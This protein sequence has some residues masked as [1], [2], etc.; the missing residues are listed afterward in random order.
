MPICEEPIMA[1]DVRLST[2]ALAMLSAQISP[3]DSTPEAHYLRLQ[4]GLLHGTLDAYFV[5]PHTADLPLIDLA[6]VLGLSAAE[7]LALALALAVESDLLVGRVIAYL[8]APLGGS[9]PTVGLLASLGISIPDLVDGA[10][11]ASGLLAFAGDKAPLPERTLALPPHLFLALNGRDGA[12]PGAL[13]TPPDDIPLPDS[14]RAEAAQHGAHL[15]DGDLLIL[16]SRAASEGRAAASLVAAA[17]GL[18]PVYLQEN[19]IPAGLAPWL[20]LRGRLPVFCVELAPGEAKTLPAIPYY[21]GAL[22]SVCGLDGKLDS[23]GF[24]SIQWTL[25][26]PD[27][28]EREPLW[29]QALGDD[30]LANDAA[31]RYRLSSERIAHVGRLA[32]HSRA[33]NGRTRP[34]DYDLRDALRAAD[35]AGL[36]ALAQPVTEA[37]PDDALIVSAETRQNLDILLRRCLWRE[38]LIEPLGISAKARYA[39]GVRA[40]L[41][42]PSGTGKTL[43]ACWLA[44][45]LGLPLFRVDL[46]MITSKYIGETEKNLAQ[47]L[48]R[49]E[50]AGVVL[51]FDEA[52][53]LFGKRTDV[54]DS[55]DRFANAQTN[56]LLQRIETF[57]GI[58]I[59][60]SNSQARFDPA[61]ARRLDMIIEF[62]PPGADERRALWLAHLGA[63]HHIS[64]RA[65]NK[66]AALVDISGGNIRNA[67][68]MAAVIAEGQPVTVE[69]LA[70]GI[71]IELGKLGRQMPRLLDEEAQP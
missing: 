18:R 54:K 43:A 12:I 39:P 10:A 48:A 38:R 69:A 29:A 19:E 1:A 27:A 36:E 32:H 63:H 40:L 67:V 28:N 11:L 49:A 46:A 41:T 17:R 16:R 57:D 21:R 31:Q 2:Y 7:L 26:L 20:I 45:T 65:L 70:Q 71:A 68:L 37:I 15:C 60:T 5:T 34:T 50:S 55:N 61:F 6:G 53:S 56:Y 30:N 42:G 14:I 4:A 23:E 59:L 13:L 47:L 22:L 62:P 58:A 66:I 52:D 9:R 51:L 44:T 24:T 33:L 8:Q 35:C 3:E 25:A 64:G